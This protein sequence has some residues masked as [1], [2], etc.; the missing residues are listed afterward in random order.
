MR[1]QTPL[2]EARLIRRYKRF[3]ADMELADGRVVV[4]HCANPGAMLGMNDAGARCWLQDVAGPSRTL[5]RKLGYSWKLVEAGGLAVVDTGMAN[6][7]VGEALRAGRLPGFEAVT[8]VRAEVAYGAG[9]RV[10][11]VLT[12][13]GLV[14]GL[15]SGSAGGLDEVHLEVK[16]VTLRRDGWA[17]FP[18]SVTLRG[19]R[20]LTELADLVRAGRRAVQ[21]FL[22]ARQACRGVRL[23]RDIDPGYARQF[24]LARQAGVE[25]LAFGCDISVE[26]VDLA[27]S[28]PMDFG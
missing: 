2:I 24:D 21:L 25:M 12:G 1:F 3:L 22:V 6:R 8:G 15:A 23:A 13:P 11:F 16:S 17:E 19:A 20:H 7:V 9:S 14:S 5:R 4:A 26:G 27:G 18:D 28:L 10:D